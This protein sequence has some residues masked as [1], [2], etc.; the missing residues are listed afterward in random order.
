MGAGA[1]HP[2]I[3]THVDDHDHVDNHADDHGHV[4]D[5][6]DDH[7]HNDNDGGVGYGRCLNLIPACFGIN[8]PLCPAAAQIH[9]G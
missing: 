2:L 4:V 6:A 7:D 8:A 9:Y 3:T 1:P 5:H